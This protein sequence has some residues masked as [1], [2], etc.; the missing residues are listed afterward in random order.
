MTTRSS[1]WD[2]TSYHRLSNPQVSWGLKV[3][4]RLSL[5]G[6]ERV[7]D[8]A[9][10]SCRL[11][12]ELKKRLPRG[13]V[14]GVDLSINMLSQA[15]THTHGQIPLV[16]AD[17][18]RL[19]LRPVFDGIFSTAAFHWVPDHRLLFR[20]LF[21]VLNPG[22]WLEA[23]CGG[24][25]NLARIHQRAEAI[26]SRPEYRGYFAG[27]KRSTHYETAETF[28]RNMRDAGFAEIR[29]WL[30]QQ[31]AQMA[32][33]AEFKDYLSTVTL[34]EHTARITDPKLRQAFAD[35]M[36]EMAANDD[37]PFVMDYWR[38]NMSARKSR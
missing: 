29:V 26:L 21:R 9:C 4:D 30:E 10:G 6:D 32:D 8:A 33:A 37:P 35:E 7:L 19:P 34:R 24:G 31:P 23:Q 15:I 14:V 1:E 12:A 16:Q 27:W 3:L 20:S 38:L 22:G 25:P 13:G 5:R 17:L 18:Q 36:A 11:T 2:A 28:E